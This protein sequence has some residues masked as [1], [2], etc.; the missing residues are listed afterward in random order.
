MQEPPIP[1]PYTEHKKHSNVT[2]PFCGHQFPL[3]WSRY[4]KQGFNGVVKCPQ[5]SEKSHLQWTTAYA[6]YLVFITVVTA[7]VITLALGTQVFLTPLTSTK[8][9]LIDRVLL[10]IDNVPLLVVTLLCI[11]LP[12]DKYADA[13][14]RPLVKHKRKR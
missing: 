11:I 2:C 3:T 5:C 6:G 7:V 14:Y 9:P 12:I 13:H 10:M 8:Q 1:S 4:W